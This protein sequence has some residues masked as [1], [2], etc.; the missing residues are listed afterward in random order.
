MNT[1]VFALKTKYNWSQEARY[2]KAGFTNRHTNK[3]PNTSEL[4]SANTYPL[5]NKYPR[6]TYS[7]YTE[8]GEH[9]KPIPPSTIYS[10][11]YVN[12]LGSLL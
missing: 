10:I 4:E 6:A 9:T 7:K 12:V 2:T 11:T 1:M 5:K 8:W 3:K